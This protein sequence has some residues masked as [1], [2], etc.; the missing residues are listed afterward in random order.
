MQ[1]LRQAH[2]PNKEV[3][4]WTFF[5]GHT[6][7]CKRHTDICCVCNFK[8]RGNYSCF[9]LTDCILVSALC[10]KKPFLTLGLRQIKYIKH[11]PVSCYFLHGFFFLSELVCSSSD[12]DQAGLGPLACVL[13]PWKDM[14]RGGNNRKKMDIRHK[15]KKKISLYPP[16]KTIL[17]ETLIRKHHMS[18]L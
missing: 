11:L 18:F 4:R 13:L 16:E 1:L 2:T 9:F 15:W 12:F 8:S 6:V 3:G 7:G 10:S 17:T 14:A 5:T